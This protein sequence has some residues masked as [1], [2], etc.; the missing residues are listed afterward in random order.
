MK[1]RADGETPSKTARG[2]PPRSIDLGARGRTAA[3]SHARETP[4]RPSEDERDAF[5]GES[6]PSADF[7]GGQANTKAKT[8][9]DAIVERRA[10]REEPAGKDRTHGRKEKRSERRALESAA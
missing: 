9:V 3:A 10:E 2:P 4:A 1:R 7:G 5:G 8:T 6:G